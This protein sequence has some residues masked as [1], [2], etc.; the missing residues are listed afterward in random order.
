MGETWS[1]GARRDAGHRHRLGF[2]HVLALVLASCG[3]DPPAGVQPGGATAPGPTTTGAGL[4]GDVTPAVA[5]S[6]E[7]TPDASDA[8]PERSEPV[9]WR[10]V[11][12]DVVAALA[13][14]GQA[15]VLV[16]LDADDDPG[17]IA[18]VRDAVLGRIGEVGFRVRTTFDAVPAIAGTVLTTDA[19]VALERDPGVVA[20][21]LDV[22]GAGD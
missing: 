12:P 22:G 3:S 14:D 7:S 10:K 18:A 11:A 13:D 20:I 9:T 1:G 19:L 4:G 6:R 8:A 15:P 5:G 16:S 21:A 17:R 2:R